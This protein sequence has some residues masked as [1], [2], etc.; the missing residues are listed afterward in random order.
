CGAVEELLCR[1][2][3]TLLL[4]QFHENVRREGTSRVRRLGVP[5]PAAELEPNLGVCERTLGFVP[6]EPDLCTVGVALGRKVMRRACLDLGDETIG[7]LDRG[8]PFAELVLRRNDD[9]A[10]PAGE[11]LLTVLHGFTFGLAPE[12]HGL[13][14]AAARPQSRGEIPHAATHL[15]RRV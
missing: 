11:A 9:A 10:E 8:G 15:E 2:E 7:P 6:C 12:R 5:R 4:A 13:D 1:L 3:R 14:E